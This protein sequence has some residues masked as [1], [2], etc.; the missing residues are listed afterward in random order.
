M[1]NIL[2]YIQSSKSGYTRGHAIFHFQTAPQTVAKRQPAR[3]FVSY[4]HCWATPYFWWLG[5]TWVAGWVFQ[6][7]KCFKGSMGWR[8]EQQHIFFLGDDQTKQKGKY[9]LS[10]SIND[11][12][13][14]VGLII[15]S[16]N[17]LHLF[18]K[19]VGEWCFVSGNL[20]LLGS[21]VQIVCDDEFGWSW[22]GLY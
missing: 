15:F 21:T 7:E 14:Y 12:K 11:V 22:W 9:T 1:Q 16:L 4:E 17:L 2:H 6:N 5:S 13:T 19:D 18:E 3:S 10:L 20:Q 8:C